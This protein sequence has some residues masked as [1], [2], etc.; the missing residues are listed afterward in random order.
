MLYHAPAWS[1]WTCMLTNNQMLTY[2]ILCDYQVAQFM[3]NF[4]KMYI[5]DLVIDLLYNF[6]VQQCNARQRHLIHTYI[7][8]WNKELFIYIMHCAHT[9]E[10][11]NWFS[12]GLRCRHKIHELSLFQQKSLCR[13]KP[14]GKC[15]RYARYAY[16]S[17]HVQVYR[18]TLAL[19]SP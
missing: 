16:I 5:T 12:S 11:W 2:I 9:K 4:I 14:C 13:I 15:Y 18:N 6:S 1:S 8:K 19:K 10:N 3:L 7:S 17:G